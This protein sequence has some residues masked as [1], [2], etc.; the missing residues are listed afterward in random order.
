M[1]HTNRGIV[2]QRFPSVAALVGWLNN[3]SL[4]Y[5]RHNFSTWLMRYTRDRELVVND[6]VYRYAECL[7]LI[8]GGIE[9]A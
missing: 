2:I 7:N 5:D 4:R 9:H 8:K 1:G 6:R 3:A